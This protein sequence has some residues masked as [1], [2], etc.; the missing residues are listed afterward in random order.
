PPRYVT[1]AAWKRLANRAG[2][3][4]NAYFQEHRLADHM[5]RAELAQRLLGDDQ[6]LAGPLLTALSRQGI[7]H[8]EGD[9]ARLPGRRADTTRDEDRLIFRAQKALEDAGLTPPSPQEF[10]DRLAAKPAIL[11]GV[12]KL[13]VERRVVIR[14]PGGL[15][16][17]AK[18]IAALIESLRAT[19]W[20]VFTIPDFKERFGLT[21]KWAVPLLEYLDKVGVT[22]RVGDQ[23]ELL[24]PREPSHSSSTRGASS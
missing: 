18:A 11:E 22:R 5:P 9:R 13:L 2:R 23:R 1:L 21:R 3:M 15:I 4:L 20:S 10:A 12:I 8:L 7:V 17:S 14:L 19:G 16:T 6:S 24:P